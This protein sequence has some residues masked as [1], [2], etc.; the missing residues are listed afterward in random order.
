MALPLK[1]HQCTWHD[2]CGYNTKTAPKFCPQ[3]KLW[4]ITNL[5][6]KTFFLLAVAFR[7][8]HNK[9]KLKTLSEDLSSDVI[10]NS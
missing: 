8:M 2:M 10:T 5:K 4:K 3:N 6:V 1:K 7:L 9:I